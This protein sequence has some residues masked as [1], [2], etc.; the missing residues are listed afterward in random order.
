MFLT[1]AKVTEKALV[2]CPTV[3]GSSPAGNERKRQRMTWIG[4]FS[5]NTRQISWP[6]PLERE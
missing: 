5:E 1:S 2:P 6:T 3:S 4:W